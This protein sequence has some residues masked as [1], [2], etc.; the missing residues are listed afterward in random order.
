MAKNLPRAQSFKN[1]IDRAL[2]N[3]YQEKRT[4]LHPMTAI[5]IY[6]RRMFKGDKFDFGVIES[7]LQSEP[8]FAPLLANWRLRFEWYFDSDANRYGWIDNNTRLTAEEVMNRVHH[9]Y[10]TKKVSTVGTVLDSSNTFGRG[11]ISDYAGIAPEFTFTDNSDT[12]DI[13]PYQSPGSFGSR[14]NVDFHL[15]YLNIIRNYHVNKQFPEIAYISNLNETF[16]TYS[17]K[18]LDKLFVAL[19]SAPNG[20]TFNRY[21]DDN[22]FPTDLDNYY[23][24]AIVAFQNYLDASENSYGGL[25][26]TQYE[27]DLFQNLLAK[28]QN[29]LKSTITIQNNGFTIEEF[30]LKNHLQGIYDKIFVSGGTDRELSRTIWGI[31]SNRQ[32][33]IPELLCVHSEIIGTNLIT[34]TTAGEA[35]S[36]EYGSIKNAPG[37]MAGNINARRG[38]GRMQKFTAH[39]SGS[40]MCIVTLTP[41]IDYTQN[42]ERHL[43]ETNFMDEFTPDMARKGFEDIPITDYC[44]LPKTILDYIRDENNEIERIDVVNNETDVLTRKVGKQIAWLREMT[45]VNRSHGELSNGGY[46]RDWILRRD[47]LVENP[48]VNNAFI[49]QVS[50]YGNPLAFQ[51]PFI[52]QTITDPNFVLQV[53]FKVSAYRPIPRRFMPNLGY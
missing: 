51:Y 35:T 33:D 16:Q 41:L 10:I 40:L 15:T 4:T 50:P 14:F 52:T 13:P 24:S 1:N 37:S 3:L 12:S 36:D 5:P 38:A 11:G 20:I 43:L 7:L 29:L 32:Y 25:F 23:Q 22:S 48:S 6:Y 8:T 2:H 9:T 47:Y 31:D 34:S 18:D 49:P 17:L 26:V 30:R 27:P 46:K 39:T 42:I 45:A 21:S 28:D 53:G 44:A 19:R